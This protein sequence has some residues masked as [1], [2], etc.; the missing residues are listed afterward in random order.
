MAGECVVVDNHRVLHGRRSY[1]LQP[2][3]SRYLE[4][5]YIDW[6]EIRSRINVL[7]NQHLEAAADL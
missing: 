5:G 1:V 2:G 7:K 4:G 6:D 3:G